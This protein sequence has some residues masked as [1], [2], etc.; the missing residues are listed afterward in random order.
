MKGLGSTGQMEV[1]ESNKKTTVLYYSNAASVIVT[2]TG[3]KYLITH[4]V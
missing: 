3:A 4:G 2:T 1:R